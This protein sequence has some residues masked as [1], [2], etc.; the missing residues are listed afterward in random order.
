M[1]TPRPL[2][3]PPVVEAIIDV[4]ARFDAPP[5]EE[6]LARVGAELITEYP[7]TDKRITYEWA[8]NK[9]EPAPAKMRVVG[10]VYRSDAMARVVQVREDGCSF[11]QLKPYSSWDAAFSEWRRVWALYRDTLSPARVVRVSTR[12]INRLEFPG[13]AI[14]F[15]DMLAIGPRLPPSG[16]QY[17]SAFSTVVTIPEVAPRTRCVLR[18]SYEGNLGPDGKVPVMLDLDVVRECDFDPRDDAGIFAAIDE[19]RPIK[20]LMFFGSLTD[21]AVEVFE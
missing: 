1:S 17:L 19:L 9:G 7:Q 5:F 10:L 15:D 21:K 8:V 6:Q 20:N 14:D 12:F 2:R 18:S 13:A 4:L 3:S 11:S 16:P